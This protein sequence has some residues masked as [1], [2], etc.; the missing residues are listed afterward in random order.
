VDRSDGERFMSVYKRVKFDKL[1]N[2]NLDVSAHY[3]IAAP[4]TPQPVIR[5]VIDRADR[6]E[7]MTHAKTEPV[8]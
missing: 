2:L 1:S 7:P 5:E 4:A 8:C 6:G 3:L